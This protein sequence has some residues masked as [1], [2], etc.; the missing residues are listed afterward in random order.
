MTTASELTVTLLR[1]GYLVLLWIFVL[2]AIG[3][4]RRDLYGTRVLPRR[5][6][7]TS[8]GAAANGKA[9]RTATA[10]VAAGAPVQ[11]PAQAG[12]RGEPTRLIVTSGPLSG[13]TVPLGPSA[14]V[15][16]RAA[17]CSL[18]LED[19]FASSRH[20][21]IFSQDGQ[22]F[23][24]DLGSTNGTLLDGARLEQPTRLRV[25]SVLKI[26]QSQLELQR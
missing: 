18:V 10:P 20:A 5:G 12:G 2:S 3:V 4:L 17:S 25:G 21:R 6:R 11:P 15:I 9:E 1:W 23:V 24:E 14:V 7:S 16:G 19:N 22:W 8:G 26:G 13:T